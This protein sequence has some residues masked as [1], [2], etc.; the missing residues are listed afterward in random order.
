MQINAGARGI[1]CQKLGEA[2][3]TLNF[4]GQL[5]YP[6]LDSRPQTQVFHDEVTDKL[7][8]LGLTADIVS[9]GGTPNSINIGKLKGV[10]E[11]R[12]GTCIFNDRMMIE[13]SVATLEDCAYQIYYSVVSRRSSERGILDA[14]SKTLTSDTG[15][16]DRFGH[17]VEHPTARIHIVC[18]RTRVPRFFGVQ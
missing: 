15:G 3:P 7:S 2:D 5:F 6:S 1:T 12:A 17:I 14:G 4:A 8:K 11:H 10:T 16:L 9:T 18:R 13:A